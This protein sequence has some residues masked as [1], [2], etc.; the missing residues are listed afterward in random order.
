MFAFDEANKRNKEAMDLVLKSYA[1]MA[2]GFQAI[3]AEATDY[4]KRSFEESV[5]HI[6]RLSSV[7]SIE[8]AVELQTNFVKS[9]YEG[10]VAEAT[11]LGEM[12]AD[13]ARSAYKS[14]EAPVAKAAANVKAA[15]AQAAAAA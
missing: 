1:S 6:E 3:A 9:A 15:A 5:A 13:L 8:T 12:Y 10:Y 2:K 7:R 4:S 14:Y 11:K